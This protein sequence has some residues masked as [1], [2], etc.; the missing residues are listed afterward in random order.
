MQS[1][2]SVVELIEYYKDNEETEYECI[3]STTCEAVLKINHASKPNAYVYFIFQATTKGQ[4]HDR[5]DQSFYLTE[6]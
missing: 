3:A 5:E 2:S 1:F 6:T 4:W